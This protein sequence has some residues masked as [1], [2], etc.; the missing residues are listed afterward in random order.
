[1]WPAFTPPRDRTM[2][3]SLAD[4]CAA[5]YNTAAELAERRAGAVTT[6]FFERARGEAEHLRGFMRPDEARGALR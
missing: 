3:R 2:R 1:M 6:V 5:A 4:Y